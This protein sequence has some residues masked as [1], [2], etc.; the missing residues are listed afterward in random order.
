VV[1]GC[2]LLWLCGNEHDNRQKAKVK[3][4][5]S[6]FAL[7]IIMGNLSTTQMGMGQNP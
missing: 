4:K 2:F 3:Y 7:T 6:K 1:L 5:T